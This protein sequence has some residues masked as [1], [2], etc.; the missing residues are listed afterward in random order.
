MSD[1]NMKLW[2][3]V[4]QTDP[5]QT[6]RCNQRGGFTAIGA[7]YQIREATKIWGP[8]GK[9]WGVR[10]C[11]YVEIRNGEVLEEVALEATFWYP[12]GE[13][14]VSTDIAYKAG[15]DTRKKLLTD[16]TTKSLSKL[17][18]NSDVFE[19]KFDDNKYVNERR[20]QIAAVP[21]GMTTG[22]KIPQPKPKGN[23]QK[24]PPSTTA[25]Q[26]LARMA[27]LTKMLSDSEQEVKSGDRDSCRR[28][29][30][31]RLDGWGDEISAEDTAILN[32]EADEVLS[33]YEARLAGIPASD[34]TAPDAAT[35]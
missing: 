18:F 8:Y 26:Y 6:K 1:A 34:E 29:R 12:A 33:L 10:D 11:E 27:E 22:N 9:T 23:G 31:L 4:W 2:D 20:K 5:A 32:G 35:D 19:G 15:N 21:P 25:A 28:L 7:Q 13:F 30:R 24:L 14:Q 16:L 17:G 3:Q